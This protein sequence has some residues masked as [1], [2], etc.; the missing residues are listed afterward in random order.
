MYLI[1]NNLLLIR[2]Y[3]IFNNLRQVI[4]LDNNNQYNRQTSLIHKQANHYSINPKHSLDKTNP[5]LN[6]PSHNSRYK[7]LYNNK[8]LQVISNKIKVNSKAKFLYR[9]N[10]D[11]H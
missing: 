7:S 3:K 1:S 9:I 6:F 10:K 8:E 4:Y 5:K 2:I 11:F